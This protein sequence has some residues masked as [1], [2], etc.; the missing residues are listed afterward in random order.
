[1]AQYYAAT[2]AQNSSN[3]GYNDGMLL[4]IPFYNISND[5]L[6]TYVTSFSLSGTPSPHFKLGDTIQISLTSSSQSNVCTSFD[7]GLCGALIATP[8]TNPSPNVPSMYNTTLFSYSGNATYSA[9]VAANNGVVGVGTPKNMALK[10]MITGVYIENIT[11]TNGS[12]NSTGNYPFSLNVFKNDSIILTIRFQCTLVPTYA[13]QLL[14]VFIPFSYASQLY[15]TTA[16]ASIQYISFT[17]TQNPIFNIGDI[18]SFNLINIGAAMY[19]TINSTQPNAN[20]FV[21]EVMGT[22]M[23]TTTNLTIVPTTPVRGVTSKT[24][25]VSATTSPINVGGAI[26]YSLSQNSPS[27]VTLANNNITLTSSSTIGRI[28]TIATQPQTNTYNAATAYGSFDVIGTNTIVASGNFYPIATT[29]ISSGATSYPYSNQSSPLTICANIYINNTIISGVSFVQY[30]GYIM[31]PGSSATMSICNMSS[32]TMTLAMVTFTASSGSSSSFNSNDDGN[33]FFIPF[34]NGNTINSSDNPHLTVMPT[35]ISSITGTIIGPNAL[36]FNAGDTIVIS[37]SGIASNTL[38][39]CTNG[40]DNSVVGSI[41]SSNIAPAYLTNYFVLYSVQP[42]VNQPLT[43]SNTSGINSWSFTYTPSQKCIL[44]GMEY[45]GFASG[46]VMDDLSMN[47]VISTG[48]T[49]VFTVTF[50]I[51]IN[52]PNTVNGNANMYISNNVYLPFDMSYSNTSTPSITTMYGYSVGS[53]RTINSNPMVGSQLLTF[54]IS[55]S[56]NSNILC[57]TTQGVPIVQ[58]YGYI[59]V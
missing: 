59:T 38:S 17:G 43:A 4:S 45:M 9:S 14:P 29:I 16:N 11:V 23:L 54:T 58:I 24:I 51:D 46:A 56:N 40:I 6:P 48:G 5:L 47:L 39:L 50:N 2:Y 57:L 31:S 8:T 32:A 55:A 34:I 3:Y 33:L 44:V 25:A 21:A 13:M 26:T 52:I 22:T 19:V 27:W 37:L 20:I 1:V 42:P 30:G 18:F 15:N 35:Y 28:T 49:T 41:I 36:T 53:N 12:T 7:N 10:T